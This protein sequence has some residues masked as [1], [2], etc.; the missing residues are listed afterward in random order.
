MEK[1]TKFF[2]TS[3]T[4]Q[5]WHL[6]DANGQ[7]LGRVATQVAKLLRG[8]HK[9]MF[10]PN[11]D[12]GDFVVVVNAANVKLTGKRSELKEY[13]HY[14]G[15]PGGATFEKFQDLI[16]KH[17]ERVFAHAVKGMLPHNRLGRKIIKKMKVYAGAEHPHLAQ[18]P[19]AYN[20]N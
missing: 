13:F 6:V 14:T 19:E 18:R 8:K 4:T 16:R 10:T 17:P 9:P 20:L 11:A 12:L 15:Y 5:K 2:K 7:T 3:D 1:A